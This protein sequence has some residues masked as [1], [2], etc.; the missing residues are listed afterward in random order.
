MKTIIQGCAIL[1]ASVCFS[2]LLLADENEV[3]TSIP[4]WE[5]YGFDLVENRLRAENCQ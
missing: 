5:V 2:G 4:E 1:M 3:P